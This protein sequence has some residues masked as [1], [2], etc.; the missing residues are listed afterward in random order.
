MKFIALTKRSKIFY[1]RTLSPAHSHSLEQLPKIPAL[2][3]F[4]RSSHAH[5]F[6]SSKNWS[7]RYA[8]ITLLAL[9]W[10]DEDAQEWLITMANGD[11]RQVLSL[12]EN[13]HKLYKEITVEN[14]A[15]TLQNSYLRYDKKAEEHYNTIS[16]F[17]KSMRA[18]QPDAALYYLA[19][20]VESG[21]DPKFIARR[22]VIFAS[23]DIG[24]AD[25]RGA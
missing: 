10:L 4:L 25:G 19:R 2:R 11:A 7:G 14:L 23:E 17:I 9:V 5:K 1:C 18:C 16:A 6:L 15:N 21:E 24:L 22:M 12:L 8:A 20:M 3:L 13:T